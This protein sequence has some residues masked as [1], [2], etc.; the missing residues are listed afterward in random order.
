MVHNNI[1]YYFT[2]TLRTWSPIS[3]PAP[4]IL[5]HRRLVSSIENRWKT[6]T[7][8]YNNWTRTRRRRG[9]HV[10]QYVSMVCLSLFITNQQHKN[11]SFQRTNE[12]RKPKVGYYSQVCVCVWARAQRIY[13]EELANLMR[14]KWLALFNLIPFSKFC[15]WNVQT[16]YLLYLFPI[17]IFTFNYKTVSWFSELYRKQ[18]KVKTCLMYKSSKNIDWKQSSRVVFRSENRK[19]FLK[20]GGHGSD[21]TPSQC[22]VIQ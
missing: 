2:M 22:A 1:V 14:G 16:D 21:L 7:P 9:R 5:L 12:E 10:L 8:N 11:S 17:S 15:T 20:S 3:S 18:W 6:R 4:R 19:Q 13:T